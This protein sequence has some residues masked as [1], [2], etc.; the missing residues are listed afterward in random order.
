MKTDRLTLLVTPEEKAE[1]T[2]RADAMGISTSELVRRA[3]RSHNPEFD[4]DAVQTL[5]DELAAVV[6]GTEKQINAAL[7]QLRAF[8]AFFADPEARRAEARA[9]LERED[10]EWPFMVPAAPKSRRKTAQKA[11]GAARV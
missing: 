9:A 1:M 8:E 5:A 2:A 4:S 6:K 7:A 11:T 3:V 10:F